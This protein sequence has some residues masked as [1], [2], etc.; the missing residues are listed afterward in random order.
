MSNFADRLKGTNWA[1]IGQ[2]MGIRGY[3]NATA[4]ESFEGETL[5]TD[6]F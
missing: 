1:A 5:R 3:A 2:G 6:S 4:T